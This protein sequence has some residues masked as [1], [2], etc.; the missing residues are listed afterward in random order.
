MKV[1]GEKNMSEKKEFSLSELT[2]GG[3]PWWQA[4]VC[5][6]LCAIPMF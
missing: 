2:L 4:L 6:V 3:L 5:I 1:E